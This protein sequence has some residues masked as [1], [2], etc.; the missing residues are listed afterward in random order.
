MRQPAGR[1]LGR[2]RVEFGG[3]RLFASL[4]VVLSGEAQEVAGAGAVAL[5]LRRKPIR[6]LAMQRLALTLQH[7]AVG[8]WM[9]DGVPKRIFAQPLDLPLVP[10][11]RQLALH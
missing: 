6:E 10:R 2:A 7:G 4:R 8:H 5:A 9:R 3:I 11:Q 1:I